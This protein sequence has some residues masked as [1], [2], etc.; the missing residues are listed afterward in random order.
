MFLSAC[1]ENEREEEQTPAGENTP[2][3]INNPMMTP[4]PVRALICGE[5]GDSSVVKYKIT[6]TPGYVWVI[7]TTSNNYKWNVFMLTSLCFCLNEW[8]KAKI[9]HLLKF[10]FCHTDSHLSRYKSI[11]SWKLDAVE[12]DDGLFCF[13]LFFFNHSVALKANRR[14]QRGSTVMRFV[15]SPLLD[16][17]CE[18]REPHSDTLRPSRTMISAWPPI[19]TWCPRRMKRAVKNRREVKPAHLLTTLPCTSTDRMK[20][21]RTRFSSSSSVMKALSCRC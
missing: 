1:V 2:E 5:R 10:T 4:K 20:R 7:I 15:S 6:A 12:N 9:I 8:R 13:V 14:N 16:A 3:S 11:V 17:Q 19:M 21:F 18:S